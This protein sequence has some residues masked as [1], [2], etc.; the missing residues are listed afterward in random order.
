[1]RPAGG[2]RLEAKQDC[3]RQRKRS[4]DGGDAGD[5]WRQKDDPDDAGDGRAAATQSTAQPKAQP[6]TGRE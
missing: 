5:G 6:L 2:G 4:C 1:M 3:P